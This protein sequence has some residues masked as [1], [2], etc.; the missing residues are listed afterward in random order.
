MKEFIRLRLNETLLNERLMDVDA[1]VDMLYE[2]YFKKDIDEVI[3]TGIVTRDMFG[4]KDT[5]T[6][7]LTTP[8]AKKTH[9]LYP[10]NILINPRFSSN[11]ST[12]HYSPKG[13]V[14]SLGINDLAT[15]YVISYHNGNLMKAS[16]ELERDGQPVAAENILKEFSESKI[17]G[18]IHHELVHWID[19]VLH[20]KHIQAR[21][22]SGKGLV[23]KGLPINADKMEIQAQIHNIHQL[24]KEY[25]GQWDELTFK[26]LFKLSPTLQSVH[27]G[28]P[29]GDIRA[30]WLRDIRSRMYREGLLGKNMYKKV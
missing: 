27:K 3:R 14:I 1:D 8:L 17:K 7:I 16:R 18:S 22:N 4:R 5:S 29:L 19:D 21:V 28:L 30:N 24:K 6:D 2:E 20:N 12:N 11:I 15:A 26:D 13:Q 9:N 10:C 25:I 23:R